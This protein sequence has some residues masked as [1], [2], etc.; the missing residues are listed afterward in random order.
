MILFFD[1]ETSGLVKQDLDPLD[2]GQPHMVQLG[3]Q[4]FD[5]QWV[6]RAHLS[7]LIK[8][9][10]WEIEPGAEA[11]H[12]ISTTDCHR[13]GIPLA[14]AI[15]PFMELVGAARRVVAHNIQFDRRIIAVS[16]HRAGGS[17]LW[18]SRAAPKFYCT[19]ENGAEPVGKPAEF[20]GFKYPSLEEAV[21]ILCPGVASHAKHDVDSD[22]ADTVAVY[23]ALDALGRAPGA[24][25]FQ[26]EIV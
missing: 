14:A 8:P 26:M 13:C 21:A 5:D 25:P 2:P 9:N 22:I 12:G 15:V 1:T 20:G 11:V 7:V 17:G 16:T 6:K 23:R 4:L 18:W 10:D 19:M 24:K 3:A